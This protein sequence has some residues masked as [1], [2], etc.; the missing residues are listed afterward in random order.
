MAIA[1]GVLALTGPSMTPDIR[2]PT[3]RLWSQEKQMM[4]STGAG[5]GEAG[6]ISYVT[7]MRNGE[8]DKFNRKSIVR[9]WYGFVK[10]NCLLYLRVVRVNHPRVGA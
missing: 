8:T 6:F 10:F 2:K 9:P 3:V 4:D 5:H 1:K 7:A